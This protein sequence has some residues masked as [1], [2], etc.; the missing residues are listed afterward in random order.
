MTSV[1]KEDPAGA[2]V[3]GVFV[4][5]VGVLVAVSVGIILLLFGVL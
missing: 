1:V 4:S 5:L 2:I 3:F